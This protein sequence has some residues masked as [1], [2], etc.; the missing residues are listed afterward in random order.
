MGQKWR[1]LYILIITYN[2]LL[3]LTP[4]KPVVIMSYESDDLFVFGLQVCLSIALFRMG[5]C[6]P[7]QLTINDAVM[8]NLLP[9]HD[10][11]TEVWVK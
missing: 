10:D 3:Y 9:S 11:S 2:H 1:Q 4:P 5:Q 7:D 8:E 6:P